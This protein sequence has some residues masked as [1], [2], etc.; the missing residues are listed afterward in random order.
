MYSA[1]LL[2]SIAWIDSGTNFLRDLPRSALEIPEESL[3]RYMLKLYPSFMPLSHEALFVLFSQHFSSPCARFSLLQGIQAKRT[4]QN[5][6]AGP[7][8][9]DLHC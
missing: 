7:G 2:Q 1:L 9:E 4:G 5:L 3:I 8:Q 6:R